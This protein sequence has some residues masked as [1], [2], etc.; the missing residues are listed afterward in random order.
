MVITGSN[1]LLT[2]TICYYASC[3]ISLKLVCISWQFCPSF[4][5]V[6]CIPPSFQ[7]TIPPFIQ[8]LSLHPYGP[9]CLSVHL[10]QGVYIY[11]S[12]FLLYLASS[13]P[14]SKQKTVFIR[15]MVSVTIGSYSFFVQDAALIRDM[16]SVTIGFYSF[17]VQDAALVRDKVLLI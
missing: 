4:R 3:N 6:H 16:V 2:V 14:L 17:F 1:R 7:I 10:G 13:H 15:D 11:F 8:T 5:P 9:Q 12:L